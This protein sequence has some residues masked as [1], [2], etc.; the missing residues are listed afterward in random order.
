MA[1]RLISDE[2]FDAIRSEALACAEQIP[3]SDAVRDKTF[4]RQVADGFWLHGPESSEQNRWLNLPLKLHATLFNVQSAPATHAALAGVQ[5]VL[6]A[7]FSLLTAGACIARHRDYNDPCD[8]PHHWTLVAAPGCTLALLDEGIVL[9]HVEREWL[10]FDDSL[11]HEARN[12]SPRDR[13]VLYL[14]VRANQEGEPEEGK[15]GARPYSPV[16]DTATSGPG[17]GARV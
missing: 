4:Q 3:V 6:V 11:Y 2:L 10:D 16:G 1:K 13:I 8:R 12:D 17:E 7:G 14:V 9:H 5:G 15:A